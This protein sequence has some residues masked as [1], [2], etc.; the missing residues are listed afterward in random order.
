[1]ASCRYHPNGGLA[2]ISLVYTRPADRR[3]HYAENLVYQVTMKAKEAGYVPM[4]YTDAD[5]AASNACYEKIGYVLRGK[6]CSIG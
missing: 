5:Y 1:M 4:L 6:L 2:S 3:K